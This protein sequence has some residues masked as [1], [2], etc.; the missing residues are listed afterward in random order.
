MK[1]SH[2]FIDRPIFASV[3][4][5]LIT[6]VGAV[7]YFGLPVSQYP[8]IVPPSV[9][10]AANY[11]G[12]SP[13]T[14]KKTVSQPLEEAI[15]GV[16][17]MI[18]M[19]SQSS[20]DGSM[21][22]TVTFKT[23]TDIDNAQILVQNRVSKT[24]SRLPE[25]VRAIGVSVQKRS[26]DIIMMITLVSPQGSRDKL[27]LTNYALTQLK[28]RL[29]R[30]EGV[31]EIQIFGAKEYSMRIWM[32]PE[33]LAHLKMSPVEVIAA[34]REQNKQIAAGKLNQPPLETGAAYEL[35]INAQGRLESVEQFENIIVK[36]AP[37]GRVI[38]LADVARVELGS[39][40][41]SD[42]SYLNGLQMVSIAAFQLPG[43]NSLAT[44]QR[45]LKAMEDIKP[46]LPY[47]VDYRIPFNT[48]EYVQESISAVYRTIMEAVILVVLV[49]MIFL[50]NWRAAVI[51]LFAIPVSLIGTFATMAAF[52]FSINN[53]SL[54]GLVLAI[55]IVVDDAIVVVENVERNMHEGL[56]V[57]EATK[58]AM[59]QVQGALIA[60]AMVLAAV[61]LPTA[62]FIE[63]IS[64]QFYKQFAMTI[65]ASTI[66]SAIVSLTLSPALCALFLKD[67]DAKKDWFT[68]IW[69]GAFGWFF[70]LFN[71]GF[72]ALSATYGRFIA[73]L[74]RFCIVVIIL[75]AG[76]LGSAKWFFNE[77][78]TGFIPKQDMGYLF[79]MVQLPDGASFDRT[80]EV[81]KNAA[82][83]INEIDGVKD[84]IAIS[85]LSGATFARAS[86]AGA[87]FINLA[88]QRERQ[89]SGRSADVI[90]AEANM[91]LAML[92]KESVVV[93][94]AP[95]PV[96]G[97]GMGGDFKFFVKDETGRGLIELQQYTQM[98]AQ[99]ASELTPVSN[100]FTTYRISNPQLF[101]D[102][103]R[104]RAQKLNV[105][106]ASVFQALQY[107][108]GSVYVNDFNIVGRVYRVMAQAE[109]GKRSR[110]SD[111]Y[112]L[113]VQNTKGENVPLGSLIDVKRVIGPSG[114]TSYNVTT[115]AEVMGNLA[116]GYSTGQAIAAIEQLAKEALPQGMSI[117]WT[118]IAFQENA[119]KDNALW[120]F[121]M[122]TVFVFLL[123]AALYESWT[124]PLAVI[125]VVPLVLLFAIMGVYFR[126]MNNNIMTQIGFIVLIGLACKNA[127]LIVEFAN[128]RQMRGEELLSSV[129][130]AS[131]NR[132]RPILMTSLAFIGGV[133]P[134]AY[135]GGSGA[136]LRQALGTSVLFGMIGVT[137]FGCIFTPVFYY[138]LRRIFGNPKKTLDD[139]KV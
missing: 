7:A 71:R 69:E 114:V 61:F 68:K 93:A 95:P 59:T 53:L 125:M 18:Y 50:Q 99:K 126:D 52:G 40:T 45:L 60:I 44:A 9:I 26:P 31:G 65:A 30:V 73:V 91:K 136:E 101:V 78:P 138:V 113:K 98:M 119:A 135:A 76:L 14:I 132:L 84:T 22:I 6:L 17:G 88:D 43:S 103:D 79:T 131:K 105:P 118:D 89:Q 15:N 5:I 54:F 64:G 109:S 127:I 47:D 67:K 72:N 1:F 134:L 28:D 33:R 39:Y 137:V 21:Q 129:Q 11:P 34:M 35:T 75:Y 102:I 55:G 96:N 49:V 85:G 87:I 90:M 120:T 104:E 97:L 25:E 108:L 77:T 86:N 58:K 92:I 41:Y 130:N 56:G 63:G 117:E 3:I 110:T 139:I 82:K 81:V 46:T 74:A 116:P 112:N 123:L 12:A 2:F 32:D 121:L 51:P 29:A 122:C 107:Q 16:Q 10:V 20:S 133:V 62:I 36:Y 100:A 124:M 42:E 111:I 106:I 13:E 8:E 19:Q 57:R 37:D 4:S 80:N 24:E 115:A 38:R 48:T 70:D 66:F 27:Y 128:Q 83:I 23:G 94:L